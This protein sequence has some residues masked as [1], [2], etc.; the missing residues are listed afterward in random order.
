MLKHVTDYARLYNENPIGSSVS[1]GRLH[2]L[3]LRLTHE[4]RRARKQQP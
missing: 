4:S 2:P 3:R 1:V